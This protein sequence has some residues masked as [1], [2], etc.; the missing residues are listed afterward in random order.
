MK[1]MKISMNKKSVAVSAVLA[2]AV[3]AAP[4]SVLAEDENTIVVTA[5]RLQQDINNTLAD[6]IV[7]ERAEIEKLQPQSLVDL[8][9]NI[10]GID[11]VQ[12]GGHQQDASLFIRGAN[13]N[14]ALILIDGI[15][16]GSSTL[17]VKSV[18]NI[19]IPQIEKIEVIKG[20]RAALWGSDAIGGVIQIF[21]RRLDSGEVSASVSYGSNV[22]RSAEVSVGLGNEKVSNTITYS[23]K[24]SNGFNV[25]TGIDDDKDGFDNESL[26]LRGDLSI[27]NNAVIDWVAQAD[28]GMNE[29]DTTFG[30]DV[31]NYKNHHYG[32]RYSQKISDW[33]NQVAINQSRDHSYGDKTSVFETRKQEVKLLTQIQLNEWW[34]FGAGIE[35]LDENVERTTNDYDEEERSTQSYFINAN[36][37]D[38]EWLAEM[39]VRYDDIEKIASETTANL[40]LGYRLTS[41]D[42]LSLNFAQGFKAPSFNDLYYPFGGNDEL[43]SETSDNIELIYKSQFDN[44]SFVATLYSAEIDNLI[45]WNPG[46]NGWT[47]MNVGQAKMLGGEARLSVKQQDFEHNLSLSYVDAEDASDGSQ[48]IRRAKQRFNYDLTFSQDNLSLVTQLQYVGKRKEF[49]GYLDSYVKVNLGVS[50]NISS[51]WLV[52]LKVNDLFDEAP[53]TVDGY[54]PI[55]REYYL[56]VSYQNF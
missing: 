21:T 41:S 16:V 18:T 32:L 31:S 52:N 51:Q 27:N 55:E 12:K 15:R 5:T 42:L 38:Q 37:I 9:T 46:P 43:E 24:E 10:A 34:A 30:S 49:S 47:P 56:T 29:F 54:T 6:V 23:K 36:F 26:S 7:I 25:R 13:A 53:V 2:L 48:L 17:G 45:Q 19:S 39:A 22:T 50:Y 11:F 4:V 20:P 28:Q 3:S 1:K 44:A 14:Q 33:N 8:L 40:G 35:R